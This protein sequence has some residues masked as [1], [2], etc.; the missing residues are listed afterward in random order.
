MR[1]AS[2]SSRVSGSRRNASGFARAQARAA[3]A[4]SASC[5]R[6]VPNSCMCRAAA[7]A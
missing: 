3:T 4:T 6:V 1:E 5:S 7:I 2:T